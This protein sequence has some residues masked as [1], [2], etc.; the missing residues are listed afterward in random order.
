MNN[1]SKVIHREVSKVGLPVEYHV[2]GL[3]DWDFFDSLVSFFEKHY[4]AVIENKTD[5]INTRSWQLRSRGEYFMLEH[6]EGLGNWF[7][8]C[9]EKGDSPLMRIIA[10]DLEDRLKNVAYDQ[11]LG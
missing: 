4:G 6:N 3:D 2:L 5:G 10:D 7:Y 8:S 1:T 9:E 11:G